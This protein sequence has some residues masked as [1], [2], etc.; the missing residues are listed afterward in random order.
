VELK[1]GV[2]V[3]CS[4]RDTPVYDEEGVIVEVQPNGWYRVAFGSY[5]PELSIDYLIPT[6]E[7]VNSEEATAWRR[8]RQLKVFLCHAS[9]DKPTV[10][11]VR[12]QLGDR[13]Y[14]AW[15]DEKDIPL[16]SEWDATIRKQLEETDVVIACMS[17]T[18]VTKSGYVQEELEAVLDRAEDMPDGRVFVIMVRLDE[19]V[20]PARVS[21]WQ[22]IDIDAADAY[23]RL[24]RAL[25]DCARQLD[26]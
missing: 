11:T 25:Q 3:V 20:V 14:R 16:G 19:C 5:Q 10:R 7:F 9:E 6:D 23:E 17:K 18:S 2:R 1:P 22:H 24:E 15:I 8:A 13:G 21:R 26:R 12:E 4:D